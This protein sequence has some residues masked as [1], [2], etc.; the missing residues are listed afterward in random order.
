MVRG[1]SAQIFQPP[2]NRCIVEQHRVVTSLKTTILTSSKQSSIVLILLSLAL[3]QC[4]GGSKF[5]LAQALDMSFAEKYLSSCRRLELLPCMS[6]NINLQLL[7]GVF[8]SADCKRNRLRERGEK[9]NRHNIIRM[10]FT[11]MAIYEF[12]KILPYY[13]ITSDLF[14]QRIND[15]LSS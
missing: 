9:K 6:R 7:E 10:I 14:L 13:F 2:E 4:C 8:A 15:K 3:G 5:R 1:R 12:S 11:T